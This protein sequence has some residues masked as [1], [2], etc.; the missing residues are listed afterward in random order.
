MRRIEKGKEPSCLEELR[1]TPGAD[2]SSVSGDQKQ[3][4][5]K[6]TWAEQ[7]GLCAYCMS[8]LPKDDAASMKI[9]HYEARAG[10]KDKQFTW[11]NL[12]GVCLGD[13]GIREGEEGAEKRFHCDTYRGHLAK[14]DQALHV[15]PAHHPPDAGTRFSYTTAGE[16]RP[17]SDLPADESARVEN[18]IRRLNLNID[19]LKRNRA[20][21]IDAARKQLQQQKTV[22]TRHVEQLLQRVT[23]VDGAGR[24]PEHV[25]VAVLYFEK[26]LRQ[27]QPL[28]P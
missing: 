17:A 25:Q 27:L 21:V 20:A 8:R 22:T 15:H 1:G 26:K 13:V 19:R 5:R 6:H 14:D 24:L 4:M 9:E 3:Q 2:W 7:R 16:I 12:L 28:K 23:T 10:A 11:S 18:T